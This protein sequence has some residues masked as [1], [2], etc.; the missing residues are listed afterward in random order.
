M[1]SLEEWLDGFEYVFD[2]KKPYYEVT[3]E[4]VPNFETLRE[5]KRERVITYRFRT[6]KQATIIGLVLGLDIMPRDGWKCY[7]NDLLWRY[8]RSV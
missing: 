1:V 7:K 2:D 5:R 8:T 6:C 3:N 4:I